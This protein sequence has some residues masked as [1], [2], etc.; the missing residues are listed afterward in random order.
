MDNIRDIAVMLSVSSIAVAFIT[1]LVPD[2]ALKKTVNT[3]V[4][5]FFMCICI[6]P[7]VND[8]DFELDIS[9][10]AADE[11]PREEDFLASYSDFYLQSSEALVR[12]QIDEV[13][14]SI[15]SSEYSFDVSLV[16]DDSGNIVL[17]KITV[18]VS[19][20]DSVRTAKIITEIGS[21]TGVKP[22]VEV[23]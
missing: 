13:L 9:S 3:V 17:R 18:T 5:L 6:I 14:G 20:A 12:N 11:L 4:A 16:S 2:G 23:K 21:L 1:Y 19:Q 10:F 8:G 7:V 15:C 22:S